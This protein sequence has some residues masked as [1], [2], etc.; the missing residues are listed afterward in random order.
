MKFPWLL[1][2]KYKTNEHPKTFKSHKTNCLEFP[3]FLISW[4][5][6]DIPLDSTILLASW[7]DHMGYPL[8]ADSIYDVYNIGDLM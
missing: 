6:I 5:L 4:S 3:W 2:K 8:S 7:R 1:L